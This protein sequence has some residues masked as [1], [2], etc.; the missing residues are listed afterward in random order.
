M[1]PDFA[2]DGCRILIGQDTLDL[3]PPGE[4]LTREVGSIKLK[5]KEQMVTIHGVIGRARPP[6]RRQARP[7]ARR[8]RGDVGDRGGEVN[9]MR[10][11]VNGDVR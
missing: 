10:H 8:S 7:I 9:A 5:G 6:T 1:P 11:V 4:Y 3:L 2:A